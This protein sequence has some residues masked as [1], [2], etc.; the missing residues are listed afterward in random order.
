VNPV[1]PGGRRWPW[2]VLLAALIL[3]S[4]SAT[5]AVVFPAAIRLPR[6]KGGAASPPPALFSHRTHVTNSCYGCHPNPFPQERFAFTHADMKQGRFCATCHDGSAA[7]R[8]EGT[9]CETCHVPLD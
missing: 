1:G 9:S 3:I 4:L 5:A 7:F 8:V 6:V 2:A